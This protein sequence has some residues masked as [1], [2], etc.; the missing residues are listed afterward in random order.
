[1]VVNKK[2]DANMKSVTIVGEGK[3]YTSEADANNA[4]KTITV[5]KSM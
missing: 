5:C 4:M 3:V 2:P 1:M